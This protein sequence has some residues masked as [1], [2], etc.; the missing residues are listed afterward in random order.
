M[1]LKIIDFERLEAIKAHDC[2]GCGCII[3]DGE[4]YFKIIAENILGHKHIQDYKWC[5]KS[6]ISWLRQQI[7]E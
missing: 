7:L 6:F 2:N 1:K 3:Q 4:M 5:H